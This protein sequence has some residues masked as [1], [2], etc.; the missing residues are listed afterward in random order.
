MFFA[1]P[2]NGPTPAASFK[3]ER[4]M[5]YNFWDAALV[6]TDGFSTR[7]DVTDL[8]GRGV[9]LSATAEACRAEGGRLEIQ[10]DVGRGAR[11][12]FRFRRPVVKTGAL[13]AKVERRW[14]LVPA[15]ASA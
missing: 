7:A 3:P 2:S 9:G 11:F 14:S 1:G 4:Q 13:A 12:V 15:K 5:R 8:S 10:N 6:L